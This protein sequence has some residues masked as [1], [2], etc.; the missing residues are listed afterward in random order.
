[1]RGKWY[2]PQVIRVRL[3]LTTYALF[4]SIYYDGNN[5][6]VLNH[7]SHH[8][9][10]HIDEETIASQEDAIDDDQSLTY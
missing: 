4:N 2:F 3:E 5:A 7:H 1:M 10:N 9:D 8:N 6:P